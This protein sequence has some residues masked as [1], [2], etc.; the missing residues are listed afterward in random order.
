MV[1]H[2]ASQAGNT[3]SKS[4]SHFGRGLMD[5]LM[6]G[7]ASAGTVLLG[8]SLA[9]GVAAAVAVVGASMVLTRKVKA[10][11]SI[12]AASAGGGAVAVTAMLTGGLSSVIAA[13]MAGCAFMATGVNNRVSKAVS[14]VESDT[15][16]HG[17]AAGMV[18]GAALSAALTYG[19]AMNT[20][21][22]ADLPPVRQNAAAS[23]HKNAS[24]MVTNNFTV[25][26]QGGPKALPQGGVSAATPVVAAAS[27]APAPSVL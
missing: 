13:C 20:P 12:A 24:G 1:Q 2:M 8:G 5:S 17:L 15:A 25:I 10:G 9:A 14:R 26:A 6:P 19:A 3:V 11:T 23:A 21:E 22:S 27:K 7:L 16:R 18:A 4:Q